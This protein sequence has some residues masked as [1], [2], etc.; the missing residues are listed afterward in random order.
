MFD[1]SGR[2]SKISLQNRNNITCTV[3]YDLG[4]IHIDII[5]AYGYTSNV[6]LKDFRYDGTPY[7]WRK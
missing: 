3:S 2:Y 5:N 1:L 6:I 4:F 7:I